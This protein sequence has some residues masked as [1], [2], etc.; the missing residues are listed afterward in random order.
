M[1]GGAFGSAGREAECE[2]RGESRWVG[3]IFFIALLVL[4]NNGNWSRT[5]NRKLAGYLGRN[6][7][8]CAELCP[9]PCGETPTAPIAAQEK[10]GLHA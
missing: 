2:A 8:A 3:R 6:I 7:I 10:P 1:V 4:C 5:T 9:D